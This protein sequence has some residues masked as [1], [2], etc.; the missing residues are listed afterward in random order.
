MR[1]SDFDPFLAMLDDVA[2]LLNHGKPLT[3][4]YKSMFFRAVADHSLDELRVAFDA[5]V[6]DPQRGHFMPAPANI[7]AQIAGRAADDGRPGADEAWAIALVAK[8]EAETVVWTAETAAAWGIAKPVLANGD[9]VGARMSFRDAYHRLVNEARAGHR[10][11]AWNV[12]IGFDPAR[13]D[14]ALEHAVN[15]GR[16]PRTDAPMLAGPSG[17]QPILLAAA[18]DNPD[19]PQFARDA[20]QR[21]RDAMAAKAMRPGADGAEK[22]RTNELKVEAAAMVE[23][24]QAGGSE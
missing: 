1:E 23:A 19:I 18:M 14:L 3:V 7:L 17:T 6:K 16:L 13:R 12:S 24:Y 10:A 21:F 9:E 22:A 4:G 20:I 8:D 2:A 15:V 5:H 11:T